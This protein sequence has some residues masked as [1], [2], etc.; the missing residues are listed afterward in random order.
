MP[1]KKVFIGLQDIASFFDDWAFGFKDAGFKVITGSLKGQHVINNSKLDFIVQ[2][3]LDKLGYFKPRRISSR[4]KP[5][6]DNF[7]R[8]YYLNQVMASCD[9]F[10]LIWETFFENFEDIKYLKDNKKTVIVIFV[11]DDVRWEPAMK[12][13]FQQHGLSPF[14]YK[15]YSYSDKALENKLRFLRISEKYADVILSQPN[16]AQL[17]LRPYKILF[18]PINLKEY[19]TSFK[20]RKVPRLVHAP[21]SVGKGTVYIEEVVSRLKNEGLQFEYVRIEN[22]PRTEALKIYEDSDVIV[23]QLLLPGGGKLAHEGM[24]LGKVVLTCMGYDNY[25]Q[26]KPKDCP[27]VDV[28]VESLYDVLI[29]IIPNQAL[30]QEIADKG[31]PYIQKYHDPKTIVQEVLSELENKGVGNDYIKPTFFREKFIPEQD[32]KLDIYNQWTEYIKDGDWY[33]ENIKSGKREG[34]IF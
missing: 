12:Q 23:D 31:R 33:I 13:E 8:K 24:A 4:I 5:I 18:I 10:V 32:S 1:N 6:W 28:R 7:V 26:G 34:L 20:Q 25:D 27:L 30:R 22:K 14:T 2:E 29:S 21:T 17:G 15:N 9:V 16:I 11:G 3:K 19:S